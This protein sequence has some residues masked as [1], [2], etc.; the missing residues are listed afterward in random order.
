MF[1]IATYYI[2]SLCVLTY[3]LQKTQCSII[4]YDT[5]KISVI[6][7][8]PVIGVNELSNKYHFKLYP[9][10]SNEIINVEMDLGDYQNAAI[11]IYS[12][13]GEI[14]KNQSLKN[15]NI[16]LD[17]SDLKSGTYLYSIK[18]DGN[19]VKNDKLIIIK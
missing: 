14:V 5:V 19:Q 13:L 11:S 1:A 17:I 7:N 18:I 16:K 6:N 3:V 4:T 8:C 12:L 10:P 2:I 15:G 9:N